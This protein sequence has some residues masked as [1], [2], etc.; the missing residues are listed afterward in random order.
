MN[1]LLIGTVL[2]SALHALIPS[3]WLPI[4]AIGREA[5]WSVSKMLRITWWAGLAH[6]VSTLILGLALAV[7]GKYISAQ[8]E[9]FMHDI[10]PALLMLLGV[11][12]LYR[13]Y[14]HHHF[15]LPPEATRRGILASLLLAMFLS[16]CLEVVPYFFYGGDYGYGF[17]GLLALTY[18]VLTLGGMLLWVW[19]ANRGLERLNW[20]AWEHNAGLISGIVLI[21]SGLVLWWH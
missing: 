20:H 4:V 21:V 18:A 12:Y 7:L 5:K 19:L 9:G 2:L 13:H 8:I 10:A 6:V 11:F 15:H 3:H 17:V 14:Y 1:T 16:P